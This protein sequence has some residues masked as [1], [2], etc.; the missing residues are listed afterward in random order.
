MTRNKAVL[1]G[2]VGALALGMGGW[3]LS[4]RSA[5]EAV[6]YKTAVVE[7]RDLRQ[8]VS[9]TGTVQPF[10]TVDIKS[11]AGGEV[12]VLAVDVGDRV[13][14]GDLIARIDPSDSQTVYDQANADV[15]AARARVAQAQ[16]TLGLQK[17]TTVTGIAQAEA[18]VLSAEARLS[19]AQKEAAAQPA[20]TQAAIRQARASLETAQKQLA[21]LK[22]GTDPQTRADARTGFDTAQANLTNAELNLKRQEQLLTKGFVAQAA[23]D[24]AKAERDVAKAQAEGARTRLDTVGIGQEA[25]I[26]AAQARV[27]EAR[28]AVRTAE[29]N[30]M[31]VDLKRQDV[32]SAEAALAQAR[33]NLAT[34]RANRAQVNIRAADIE[35]A[36]AQI[37]RSDASLNNARV[38]LDSTTI[39]APRDGVILQKYVEQGTIISSGQSFNSQGTSLVQI[40]DLS[41]I[42]VEASVDESDISQVKPGQMARLTLD[43]LPDQTVMGRVE[44]TNPLGTTDQNVTT[45]KT[46]IQVLH[47]D[48]KLRPG[49]NAECEFVVS[50]KKDVLVIPT[51]A[52]KTQQGKKTVQVLKGDG[53]DAKPEP[54]VVTTGLEAGDSVEVTSGLQEG[55]KVVTG[56][57]QPGA[58]GGPGGWGGGKGGPGGPGGGGQGG[59]GGGRGGGLG[60]GRG[61]F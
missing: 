19:Q 2:I 44:R 4:R 38:V 40:G 20:L 48:P 6:A 32:A 9:A 59:F 41:R 23:V 39:R 5:G 53:K 37:A 25:A 14:K 1:G 57:L 13:K 34:A 50:E 43:A 51:R 60:G 56:I 29:T 12:L 7:R 58:G 18:Q 26:A 49:L 11:R 17:A 3:A 33:A 52:V 22:G 55:E 42:F 46:R 45:I 16:D 54:R 27:N 15:S 8:T 36:R 31:Q 28:A 47:P 35:T 21:Q 10:T 61:G 30:R 24:Q